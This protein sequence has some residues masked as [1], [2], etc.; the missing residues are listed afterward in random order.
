MFK[1]FL[2]KYL[3]YNI[4]EA[5]GVDLEINKVILL[6]AIGFIIAAVFINIKQ[7]KISALLRG[8]IRKNAYSPETAVTVKALRLDKSIIARGLLEKREGFLKT[9]IRCRED[10]TEIDSHKTEKPAESEKAEDVS[11]KASQKDPRGRTKHY[12]IPEQSKSDAA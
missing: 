3:N 11:L 10:E 1:T 6:I 5:T 9:V 7:S 2:E 12:F 4:K 8:L